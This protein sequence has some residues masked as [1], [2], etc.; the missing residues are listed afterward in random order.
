MQTY[1]DSKIFTESEA[2]KYGI[3]DAW[4]YSDDGQALIFEIKINDR[5]TTKQLISHKNTTQKRGYSVKQL[6]TI[7]ARDDINRHA[8]CQLRWDEIYLW[9]S[10]RKS[11]NW[12]KHAMKYFE[13][14]E[15][16]YILSK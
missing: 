7:T 1:P 2:E 4:I 10:K 13:I 3:P 16:Q 11:S 15:G 6:I 14:L 9:L 5:L 8:D 12:A